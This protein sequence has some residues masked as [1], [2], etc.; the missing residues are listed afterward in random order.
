MLGQFLIFQE[1][2]V[3]PIDEG[4]CP[5]THFDDTN[6]RNLLTSV[7]PENNECIEVII[8]QRTKNPKKSCKLLQETI[9]K[10]VIGTES[11][12]NDTEFENPVQ[13]YYL[14]KDSLKKCDTLM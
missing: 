13:Y 10:N 14:L 11:N 12:I 9:V 3:G 8:H 4:G 1:K 6:L 7:L 5:F 2:S